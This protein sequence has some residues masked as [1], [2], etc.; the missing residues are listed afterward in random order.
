LSVDLADAI[1]VTHPR[2]GFTDGVQARVL[3]HEVRRAKVILK[4]FA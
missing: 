3:W 1:D 4:V 2:F